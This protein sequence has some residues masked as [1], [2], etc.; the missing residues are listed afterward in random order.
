MALLA[1]LAR[2][3]N[4]GSVVTDERRAEC[5]LLQ[6]T[7]ATW[8]ESRSD[9]CG[10]VVVG[11]WAGGEPTMDS[12]LDVCVL[13]DEKELYTMTEEWVEG[14]VGQRAPI[15]RRMEWGPLFTERRLRLESGFEVDVGFAPIQWASVEPVD[16]GTASVVGS[17]A[18]PL[19]D[20]LGVVARLLDAVSLPSG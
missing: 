3:D 19:H 4:N 5:G 14:A 10:V 7:I 15:V 8:A 20:P 17:G 11:S 9:I 6:D 2:G 18:V 12:D 13:T 1:S 16:A